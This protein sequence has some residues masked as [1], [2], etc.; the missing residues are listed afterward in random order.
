MA[1]AHHTWADVAYGF[2]AQTSDTPPPV[3][4]ITAI[5]MFMAFGYFSLKFLMK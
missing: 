3:V 2:F 4:G 5:V 1:E